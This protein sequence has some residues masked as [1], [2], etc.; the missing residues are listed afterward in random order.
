MF[1]IL[2][3]CFKKESKSEVWQAKLKE[4]SPSFGAALGKEEDQVEATRA[5]TSKILKLK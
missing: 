2:P 4:M 5:R 1:T 3:R